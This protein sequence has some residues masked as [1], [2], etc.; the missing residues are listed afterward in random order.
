MPVKIYVA[1]QYHNNY[2]IRA[3]LLVYIQGTKLVKVSL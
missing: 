2:L 1:V 3:L